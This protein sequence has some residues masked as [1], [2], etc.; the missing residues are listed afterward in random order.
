[1]KPRLELDKSNKW[2]LPTRNK[3]LQYVEESPQIATGTERNTMIF[4][5]RVDPETP[6][7]VEKC[8]FMCSYYTRIE[9]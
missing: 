3:I 1:M 7:F 2:L 4:R 8:N 9:A 5:Y 6:R